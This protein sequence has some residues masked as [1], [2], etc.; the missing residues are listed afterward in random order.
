MT[1]KPIR[2][3]VSVVIQNSKSETLFA[4]RS[5]QASS[6]P[7][8][9]SLPSHYVIENETHQDT[10][11]RIGKNKL[12]VELETEK[13]LNEGQSDRGDFILFMHDYS[14]KIIKGQLEINKDYYTD[15]KWA[16]PISQLNSMEIMGDCCRLY[17]EY[18][19]Q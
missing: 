1:N 10:V 8:A 5:P 7:L 13:L 17:K 6:Y 15:L 14:A 12:G 11:Q 16:E 2:H 19:N 3:A 18:L 9:W 4:L